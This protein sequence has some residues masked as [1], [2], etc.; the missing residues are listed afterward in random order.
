[1]EKKEA[2]KAKDMINYL[3]YLYER[4]ENIKINYKIKAI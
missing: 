4:Q 3:I 1:M 2:T